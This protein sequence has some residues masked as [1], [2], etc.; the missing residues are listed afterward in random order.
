TAMIAPPD[1]P[2]WELPCGIGP[3]RFAWPRFVSTLHPVVLFVTLRFV[4]GSGELG[5]L[6]QCKRAHR[7]PVAVVVLSPEDPT[8]SLDLVVD[9]CQVVSGQ[10]EKRKDLF[11]VGRE[12]WREPVREDRRASTGRPSVLYECVLLSTLELQQDR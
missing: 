11:E 5:R 9:P 7:V 12:V 10:V 1:L 6:P 3:A 2:E 8:G 4:L